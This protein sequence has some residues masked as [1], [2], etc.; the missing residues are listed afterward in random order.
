MSN[1]MICVG[2]SRFVCLK[3]I[4]NIHP[5]EKINKNVSSQK[6]LNVQKSEI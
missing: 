6:I 2:K 4:S 5:N 1:Y 3:V